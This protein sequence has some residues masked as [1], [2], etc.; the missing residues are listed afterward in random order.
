MRKHS[1]AL[2]RWLRTGRAVRPGAR[3]GGVRQW[4][5]DDRA[6]GHEAS[7]QTSVRSIVSLGHASARD[8][9]LTGG[10][11]EFGLIPRIGGLGWHE[12]RVRIQKRD[13]EAGQHGEP[14]AL[15]A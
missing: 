12:L 1:V 6:R 3:L 8:A 4:A 7:R 2:I 13:G 14:G 5:A 11:S 9:A 10:G 15:L